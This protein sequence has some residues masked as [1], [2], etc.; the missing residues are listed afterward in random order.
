MA[1]GVVCGAFFCGFSAA[2]AAL[3]LIDRNFARNGTF[4]TRKNS[5]FVAALLLFLALLHIVKIF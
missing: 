5:N 2:P 4:H 3:A 1:V